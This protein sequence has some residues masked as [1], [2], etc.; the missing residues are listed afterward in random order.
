MRRD[1]V[2][3]KASASVSGSVVDFGAPAPGETIAWRQRGSAAADVEATL[4]GPRYLVIAESFHPGW[5]A[6]AEGGLAL[7]VIPANHAF[8]AVRL[9]AGQTSARLEFRPASWTLGLWASAFAVLAAVGD[10]IL[11]RRRRRRP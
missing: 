8:Q 10:I 2:A 3:D 6:V 4:A 7:A 5:R 11:G 1:V 9:P